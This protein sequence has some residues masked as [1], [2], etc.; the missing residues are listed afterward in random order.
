MKVSM[1]WYDVGRP[2]MKQ[3]QYVIFDVDGTLLDTAEG[4]V[5]AVKRTVCGES[6]E[7]PSDEVL[8]TFI[9]PPIQNSFQKTYGFEQERVQQLAVMFRNHYKEDDCLL[10]AEPYEGI[11]EVC[12]SLMREGIRIGIAT[13]KRQDYAE[14]IVRQFGFGAYTDD[15]YGADNENRLKKVDIIRLCLE[16]MNCEDLGKAVMVGDSDND[17]VGA[18]AVG[19]DFIGVTYGFGFK[20][21]Q[22]VDRYS[23]VGCAAAPLELLDILKKKD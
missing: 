5:E 20:S 7:M 10:K 12:Q 22:D 18:E 9:G 11:H 1:E 8:R 2:A 4:V 21:R 3:Y 14:R 13:Y 17:A 15:I 19:I 23:N 6:L 16:R